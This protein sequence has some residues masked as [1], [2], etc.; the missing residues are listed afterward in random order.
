MANFNANL[1]LMK[2]RG[3]QFVT[4]EQPETGR[5]IQCVAVPVEWNDIKVQES[6][7]QAGQWTASLRLNLWQTSERYL[8]AI[9]QRALERGEEPRQMP[10]HT[11][12][13]NYSEQFESRAREAAK[14]RILGEHPEWQ[15]NPDLADPDYNKDLRNAIF[16]AVRTRIGTAYAQIPRSERQPAAQQPAAPQYGAATAG[17]WTP[18]TV[19]PL[20][21]QPLAAGQSAGYNPEDDDLP[22]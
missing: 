19:D 4:V 3:A 9:R 15:S 6:R 21:G 20:T 2:L 7:Q 11:V 10:S 18:P 17:Q 12:E 8:A 5:K 22:F 13:V 1:D 16:D 14:K